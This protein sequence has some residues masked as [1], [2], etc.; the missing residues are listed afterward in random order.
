MTG[1]H[2][3]SGTTL[4]GHSAPHLHTIVT[5]VDCQCSCRLGVGSKGFMVEQM[6][7]T[8]KIGFCPL[9]SHSYHM[10]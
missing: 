5:L 8:A 2:P 9:A 3:L 1:V 10:V 6:A 4:S 7:S